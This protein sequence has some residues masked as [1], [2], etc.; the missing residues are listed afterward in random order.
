MSCTGR[1]GLRRLWTL[2]RLAVLL[3]TLPR[4]SA[5]SADI[6]DLLKKPLP[7]Q[8]PS[9]L[10]SLPAGFSWPKDPDGIST[11]LDDA[12]AS[13]A[14]L[15]F[16]FAPAE[17][18]AQDARLSSDGQLVIGTGNYDF[19]L[20]SYCLHAGMFRPRSSGDGY[21]LAPLK[22]PRAGVISSLL[23][24]SAAAP[25]IPQAQIQVLIWAILSGT[26]LV[27]MP[28]EQRAVARRLLTSAELRE[29]SGDWRD[30]IPDRAKQTLLNKANQNVPDA[31]RRSVSAY[32]SLRDR[33]ESGSAS[34]AELEA[35][36]APQGDA[37]GPKSRSIHSGEWTAHEGGYFIRFLPSGYTETVVQIYRPLTPTVHV[38]AEGRVESIDFNDGRQL[39]L[40]YE[41]I[42]YVYVNPDTRA[43]VRFW[44]LRTAQFAGPTGT[45]SF[46]A[47]NVPAFSVLDALAPPIESRSWE[48]PF[49]SA[50]Q[51]A[52]LGAWVERKVTELTP[53]NASHFKEFAE[54]VKDTG[55]LKRGIPELMHPKPDCNLDAQMRELASG[56]A[57]LGSLK[58]A[59]GINGGLGGYLV[60]A[61]GFLDY[62]KLVSRI[63]ASEGYILSGGCAN[64]GAGSTAT[65][66]LPG[67][68]AVPGNT[69]SQR[70]AQ[71]PVPA[72]NGQSGSTIQLGEY[73]P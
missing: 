16:T 21:L 27:K 68:V 72:G 56:K 51:A 8:L 30:L 18:P 55:E 20:R 28:P 26:T 12:Y 45:T 59:S 36:A 3:V 23:K 11:S 7:I 31:Y 37:I 13:T 42:T 52:G 14:H 70:L 61:S 44:E 38:T 1:T 54:G 15:P 62:V 66:D 43:P 19:H 67:M 60:Q 40:S 69:N 65:V 50:A 49:I 47:H 46:D 4:A 48:I 57:L 29:L 10:T 58:G 5:W 53:E 32:L 22:G 25:D 63:G 6:S 33:L 34:Y 73:K 17:P 24:R 71:S 35:I 64:N 39:K 41:P 2:S 9:E